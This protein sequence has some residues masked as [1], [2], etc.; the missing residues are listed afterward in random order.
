MD[1]G[2]DEQV[3]FPVIGYP[4]PMS[5]SF[6]IQTRHSSNLTAFSNTSNSNTIAAST[7][8]SEL[9]YISSL[10][11]LV[12]RQIPTP[13]LVTQLQSS[14]LMLL[15]GSADGYLRTHDPRM[16]SSRAM[17]NSVKAHPGSIQGLQTTGNL[18][19]TVGLGERFVGSLSMNLIANF[20]PMARQDNLALS[21][22]HL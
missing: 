6:T 13:S 4:P 18:V 11:G 21:P 7:S 15:S 1:E 16:N 5:F 10:T 3:V 14:H 22:I 2:R 20:G 8:E 17:E 19:F 9:L 12:V